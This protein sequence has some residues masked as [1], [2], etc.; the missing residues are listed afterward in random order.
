M[1]RRRE[2]GKG[3]RVGVRMEVVAGGKEDEPSLENT[4]EF[5]GD[6]KSPVWPNVDDYIKFAENLQKRLVN[7]GNVHGIGK[8]EKKIRAELKFMNQTARPDV[9]LGLGLLHTPAHPFSS[10]TQLRSGTVSD[11]PYMSRSC[12]R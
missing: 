12:Q 10:T 4:M 7:I 9:W 5:E 8:L 2:G 6:G 1:D 11:T 3:E